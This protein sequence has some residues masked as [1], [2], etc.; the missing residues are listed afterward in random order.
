MGF[1]LVSDLG[2]DKVYV[3]A[4]DAAAGRIAERSVLETAP[5]AGPRH[6][7]FHP[8]GKLVYGINELDCTINVYALDTDKEA[9]LGPILQTISTLPEGYNNRDHANAKN[10]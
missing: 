5:G 7:C 6:M 1:A 4:I 9:V 10:A 2:Q 8:N 3:Y